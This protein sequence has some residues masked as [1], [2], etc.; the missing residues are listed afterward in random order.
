MCVGFVGCH[1]KI[2]FIVTTSLCGNAQ[3]RHNLYSY[4][5][6][7]NNHSLPPSLPLPLSSC[8]LLDSYMDSLIDISYKFFLTHI[9]GLQMHY[10]YTLSY[11]T[12]I[13]SEPLKCVCIYLVC[14]SQISFF[15]IFSNSL[16][17]YLVLPQI[18]WPHIV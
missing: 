6:I 11:L 9:P 18:E 16:A 14:I 17:I 2:K 8:S 4:L 12:L 7:V 1:N 5:H 15:P 10:I 3:V 13:C